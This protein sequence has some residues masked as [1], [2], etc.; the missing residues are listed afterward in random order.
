MSVYFTPV[1]RKIYEL[2]VTRPRTTTELIAAIW[3]IHPQD[4]P[5]RNN[6]KAHVWHMNQK[7][8]ARGERIKSL[9][10]TH[11]EEPYQLVRL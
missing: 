3:W 1:E 5:Q 10:G 7:L 8:K 6:I 11:Q 4:A 2:V 9:R